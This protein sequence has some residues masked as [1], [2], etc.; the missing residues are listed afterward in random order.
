MAPPGYGPC[1]GRSW[2][3]PWSTMWSTMACPIVQPTHGKM[4]AY[5]MFRGTIHGPVDC[6]A[7]VYGPFFCIHVAHGVVRGAPWITPWCVLWWSAMAPWAYRP[8]IKPRQLFC[9]GICHG[10][11]CESYHWKYHGISSNAFL[12]GT[13][14]RAPWY[15]P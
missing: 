6:C 5:G 10:H 13:I 14:A 11:P 2:V 3:S 1:H 7:M 9:H 12:V 8:W 15:M 4:L